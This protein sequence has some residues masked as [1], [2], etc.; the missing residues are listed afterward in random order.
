M[1]GTIELTPIEGRVSA[2]AIRAAVAEEWTERVLARYLARHS[3]ASSLWTALWE[4]DHPLFAPL[5]DA[6]DRIAASLR[7]DNWRPTGAPRTMVIEAGHSLPRFT[8]GTRN[9][10]ADLRV[11]G[12]RAG[13]TEV[14]V[15][16]LGVV[17]G[18]ALRE[19]VCQASAP[20]LARIV[21]RDLVLGAPLSGGRPLHERARLLGAAHRRGA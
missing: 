11:A 9:I 16:P 3:D 13:S 6:I 15:G 7:R 1:L 12:R 8:F 14:I 5:A 21:V 4:R 19:A 18:R 20:A 2:L 17:S 10:I